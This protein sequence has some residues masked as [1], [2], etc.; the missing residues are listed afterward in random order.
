MDNVHGQC[1]QTMY[2]DNVHGQCTRTMYTDNV[3]GQCTRTMYT[4]NVHGQCTRTMYTDKVHRDTAAM[5]RGKAITVLA[6][7]LAATYEVRVLYMGRSTV[8]LSNLTLNGS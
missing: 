7:A 6:D 2:T 1:T 4:D 5:Q 3:H 8:N